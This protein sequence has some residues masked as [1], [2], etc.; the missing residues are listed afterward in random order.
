MPGFTADE[1][2]EFAEYLPIVE[3]GT[4]LVEALV[5]THL[6]DSKKKARE[7]IKAGAI[8]INGVKVTD[9][10]VLKDTAI[11]KKGKTKFA[12]VR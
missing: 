3:K 5:S 9:E 4:E 12:I 11:V 2:S 1:I 7:F 6:A 8:T 10:I